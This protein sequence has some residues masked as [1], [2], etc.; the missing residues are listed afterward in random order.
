[1]VLL[2][3]SPEVLKKFYEGADLNIYIQDL[4]HNLREVETGTILDCKI[5]IAILNNLSKRRY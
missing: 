5:R 1:M 4:E 3:E 2:K